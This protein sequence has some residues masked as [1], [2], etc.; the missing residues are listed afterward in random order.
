M[1]RSLLK[2][3]LFESGSQIQRSFTFDV[4][5]KTEAADRRIWLLQRRLN[6]LALLHR[7]QRR[8]RRPN[9]PPLSPT[10][11]RSLR[12]DFRVFPIV[13]LSNLRPSVVSNSI[14]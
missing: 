5:V 8:R 6:R 10:S 3:E 13:P 12:Y 2:R 4:V 9:R 14:S 1:T 7:R 11:R